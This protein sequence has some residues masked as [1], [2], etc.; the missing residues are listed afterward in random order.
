MLS[1]KAVSQ[2]QYF[3]GVTNYQIGREG[4]KV[5]LELVQTAGGIFDNMRGVCKQ[6][7]G[8]LCYNGH[9]HIP[10]S[11]TSSET[12]PGRMSPQGWGMVLRAVMTAIFLVQAPGQLENCTKRNTLLLTLKLDWIL[13]MSCCSLVPR[14]CPALLRP[15]RLQPARLLYLWTFSGKSTGVGCHFLLQGFFLTQGLSPCSLHCS[16]DSSPVIHQ[17]SP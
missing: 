9:I 10:S 5:S 14:S 8:T 2:T 13:L 3:S 1:N 16:L 15:H 7:T 4:Y 6:L 12:K 17:R 11:C